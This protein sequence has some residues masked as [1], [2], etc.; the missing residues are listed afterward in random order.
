[1][2]IKGPQWKRGLLIRIFTIAIAYNTLYLDR[3]SPFFMPYKTYRSLPLEGLY[4]LL[5]STI[6]DM[7][8][9][10]DT[11]PDNLIAYKSL[12]KQV[13]LLLQVIDEKRKET[14]SNNHN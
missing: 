2:E 8:I 10:L 12:R 7:L 3:S 1:M 9:V 5:T 4:E 13:D 14:I 11:T 6:K